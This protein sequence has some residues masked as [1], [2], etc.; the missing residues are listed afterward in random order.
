MRKGLQL[1]SILALLFIFNLHQINGYGTSCQS[2]EECESLWEWCGETSDHMRF[3]CKHK[4]MFPMFSL[5]FIGSFFCILIVMLANCGGLSSGGV[6]IPVC[7]A[8]YKFDTRQAIAMSNVSILISILIR[9]VIEWYFIGKNANAINKNKDV[10][11][12]MASIMSPFVIIFAAIGVIFGQVIPELMIGAGFF[13]FLLLQFIRTLLKVITLYKQE[14]QRFRYQEVEL[15]K[16]SVNFEEGINKA[17]FQSI[18]RQDQYMPV[19]SLRY[20]QPAIFQNS[21]QKRNSSSVVLGD[22]I[23]IQQRSLENQI[24]PI[25]IETQTAKKR[26]QIHKDYSELIGSIKTVVIVIMLVVLMIV[27]LLRG[28]QKIYKCSKVDKSVLILSMIFSVLATLFM[29]KL[30]KMDIQKKQPIQTIM[31]EGMITP[32]NLMAY[33]ILGISSG[34]IQGAFGVSIELFATQFILMMGIDQIT[35]RNNI[36]RVTLLSSFAASFV[37]MTE[38]LLDYEYTFLVIMMTLLG[39]VPGVYIQNAV[40]SQTQRQSYVMIIYT[41]C[42]I[43]SMITI[44]SFEI[45]YL[46]QT[47]TRLTQYQWEQNY[48]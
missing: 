1:L 33:F 38:G 40:V 11:Y 18:T 13:I 46:I 17:L 2:N 36:L 42:M 9:F 30:V 34:L 20:L 26:I 12:N 31:L 6:V 35:T 19:E 29:I 24:L 27:S 7:L 47:E 28:Y 22:S 45:D 21:Q 3:V 14:N 41:F 39:T 10:D 16:Q 8:F 44:P 5:E 15:A 23:E 32:K 43:F 37:A 25:N 48:C 4:D